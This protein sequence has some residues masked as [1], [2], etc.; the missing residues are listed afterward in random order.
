M[1]C[2]A[3]V[4]GSGLSGHST[5]FTFSVAHLKSWSRLENGSFWGQYG[6]NTPTTQTGTNH[7]RASKAYGCA[8]AGREIGAGHGQQPGNR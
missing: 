6:V 3:V 2:S 1:P 7:F 5:C 8:K 4:R